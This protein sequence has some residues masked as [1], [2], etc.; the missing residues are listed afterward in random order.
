MHNV[1]A[2]SVTTAELAGRVV[3]AGLSAPWR[4]LDNPDVAVPEDPPAAQGD[5]VRASD[6]DR[7]KVIAELTE[8]FAEG[9]LSHDTFAGRVDAALQ[10]RARAELHGLLADL[11]RPHRLGAAVLSACAGAV[12]RAAGAADRWTRKAPAPLILPAG[13]QPRFT[14][15]R[16]P[17]CDMTLADETVSRWHASLVRSE[18]NWLL[19]DLGSTNGTT[20]NGWRVTAPT[21]VAPGDRVSFGAATFEIRTR[22][23]PAPRWSRAA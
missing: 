13:P 17:A 21:P 11:P 16:E 9:R 10:A 15:G 14:I 2:G 1:A 18:G 4:C 20:V 5:L 7:D 3:S 19:H 6:A 8:R 22:L 23:G 12:R